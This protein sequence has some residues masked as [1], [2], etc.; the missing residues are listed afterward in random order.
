MKSALSFWSTSAD[1]YEQ[2]EALEDLFIGNR[3]LLEQMSIVDIKRH[4]IKAIR[5]VEEAP[6]GKY[7]VTERFNEQGYATYREMKNQLH[8]RPESGYSSSFTYTYHPDG[9]LATVSSEPDIKTIAF[10]YDSQRKLKKAGTYQLDYYT[11]GL[12]KKVQGGDQIEQYEYRNGLLT[13][14]QFSSRPGVVACDMGTEEWLGYYNAEGQLVKVEH[15]GIPS[16]VYSLTY[17]K[18]GVLTQKTWYDELRQVSYEKSY[19]FES[20][21]LV[22]AILKTNGIVTNTTSYHYEQY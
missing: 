7:I 18:A 11:N 22:K 15:K 8:N 20:G 3:I 17:D 5:S 14:I 1:R 21:L 19:T 10:K 9:V 13:R 4:Q 16:Q 6:N 2:V 12:L